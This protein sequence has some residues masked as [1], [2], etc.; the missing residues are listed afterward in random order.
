M[1]ECKRKVILFPAEHE[2][3]RKFQTFQLCPHLLC[4]KV[5]LHSPETWCYYDVSLSKLSLSLSKKLIKRRW[6]VSF[7]YLVSFQV[8][9]KP[10]CLPFPFILGKKNSQFIVQLHFLP[11]GWAF[12]FPFLLNITYLG[13][14][15]CKL[16]S[17]FPKNF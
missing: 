4:M 10:K 5:S 2:V 15:W 9:P 17:N 8:N 14:S 12:F 11:R 7:L 16:P 13:G 3:G 1:K 6:R